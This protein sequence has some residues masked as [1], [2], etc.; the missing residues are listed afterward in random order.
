MALRISSKLHAELLAHAA[1]SPGAEVCGLLFGSFDRVEAIEAVRNVADDPRESFEID[2]APLIAAHRAARDG[3]AAILGNFH[4][5]PNDL[6]RPSR[7]DAGA[8][9]GDGAI[10]L[11]I[12]GDTIT[13]WRAVE[14]GAVHGRFD[15]V[16]ILQC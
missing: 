7:Q 2:P 15:P 4:S 13:G 16:P 6:K 8:A 5:H 11:I 12:A 10:W 9:T 1:A 14:A 3:G